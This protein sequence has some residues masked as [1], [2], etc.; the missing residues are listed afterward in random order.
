MKRSRAAGAA[1][2]GSRAAVARLRSAGPFRAG[3]AELQ[4][5][6]Q[7]GEVVSVAAAVATGELA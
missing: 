7:D 4:T 6:E 1:G 5:V 2:R 3:E